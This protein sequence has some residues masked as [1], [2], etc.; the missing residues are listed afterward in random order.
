MCT[1]ICDANTES[2][3]NIVRRINAWKKNLLA[4]VHSTGVDI[5]FD[6]SLTIMAKVPVDAGFS[7]ELDPILVVRSPLALH[8]TLGSNCQR[9]YIL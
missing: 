4:L 1:N 5:I 8:L 9:R 3:T 7:G 6:I 2:E